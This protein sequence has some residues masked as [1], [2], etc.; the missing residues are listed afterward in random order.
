MT[1]RAKFRC[2]SITHLIGQWYDREQGNHV[3]A[4][5]RTVVMSPVYGNNDPNHENT[6]FWQASP[7]GRLELQV[8]NAEAVEQFEVGKEYYLDLTPAH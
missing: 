3:D 7:S 4:P 6:K 5:M 2:E 1:V 8:V